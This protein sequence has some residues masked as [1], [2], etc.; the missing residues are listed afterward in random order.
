M[1]RTPSL[2][3][4]ARRSALLWLLFAVSPAVAQVPPRPP[5]R[6]TLRPPARDTLPADTTAQDS[7]PPAVV[8]PGLPIA[9]AASAADGLW[10]WDR[11]AL[12]REAPVSLVDLLERIPAVAAFRGGWFAQPEAAAGFGGT[13]GRLEIELDGAVLDPL[14]SSST[15]LSRIPIAQLREVRVERRL[16][17]LRIRLLTDQPTSGQP[18]SR[19]EAGIGE[20][21]ANMF[22]GIFL[23]P[24]VFIGPFGVAV[25]RL[26]TESYFGRELPGLREPVSIFNGWAKLGWTSERRGLQLEVIR[27]TLRREPQSPWETDRVRQDLI[28]RGRNRFA[29]GL[30]GEV[31]AS[32]AS[33][34]DK[35]GKSA[36]DTGDV[37]E[38]ERN[39]IQAGARLAYNSPIGTLAAA[40]RY[41]DLAALPRTEAQLDARLA[42]GLV[43]VSASL[44]SSTWK[45]GESAT[46]YD[47]YGR[48]G[49]R[50][51]AVFGE[52]TGGRRGAPD[53][54]APDHVPLLTERAGWRVGATLALGERATGSVALL[55]LEQDRSF[56]FG[57]PFDSLGLPTAT[58][59]AR[60]FE[61]FGRLVLLPGWFA[62]ESWYTNWTKLTGWTYLP[63]RTWRTALELHAVPLRSG[64]LEILGRLE[65]TYR[66]SMLAYDADPPAPDEPQPI[67]VLPGHRLFHGYLQ[68]RII[69][70]RIFARYEDMLGDEIDLLPGRVYRGPRLLYGVK[71]NL[72]N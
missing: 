15:D 7:L 29:P 54:A 34:R 30:L 66:G 35:P 68:I 31:Y 23:A 63:A 27:T 5:Q 61:A 72:W 51:F 9:G 45:S 48:L 69:D 36:A 20:P 28:L 56:P 50:F 57:L 13:A 24:R 55:N 10:I 71:W 25:E 32:R 38:V 18:Y 1:R 59:P 47:V 6:D 22:R 67:I 37:T 3:R 16:G 62:L 2:C 42:V 19:V 11:E 33:L 12:L 17:L 8:F 64:N 58:Q 4:N 60:G 39:A 26:D 65:G 40:F 14:S 44:T 52:L 43:G 70:V 21:D 53:Y 49:P 41:R 46:A